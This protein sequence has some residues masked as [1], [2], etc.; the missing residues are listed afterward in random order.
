M[1]LIKCEDCGKEISDKSS[2]CIH[3][4]CPIILKRKCEEC[5]QDINDNDKVCSYCG[6]PIEEFQK[7]DN[8]KNKKPFKD[9]TKE[10]KLYIFGKKNEEIENMKY[11]GLILGELAFIIFFVYF[12]PLGLALLMM[13]TLT[14]VLITFLIK[15][16]E[17][18]YLEHDI[19]LSN[20]PK[21]K[22][23][24]KSQKLWLVIMVIG[25]ILFLYSTIGMIA[26]EDIYGSAI[27][28]DVIGI[29]MFILGFKNK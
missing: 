16:T 15:D 1:A 29:V 5:G 14:Y 11:F 22:P 13:I 26:V 20:I 25:I 6:C 2:A 10:E 7:K 9:L 17:K 19:D 12:L 8:L 23:K 4:G 21:S 24:P 28:V 27:I 18:Y 3:C